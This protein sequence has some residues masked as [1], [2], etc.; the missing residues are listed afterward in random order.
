MNNFFS[1]L[2]TDYTKQLILL[3]FLELLVF[4]ISGVGYTSISND[5]YFNIGVDPLYWIFYGLSIPQTI[6]KFP[7]LAAAFDFATMGFLLLSIFKFNEKWVR[8]TVFLLLLNY[9]TLTGYLGHRNFQSGFVW[10]LMPLMFKSEK[11]KMLAFEM[12]RYWILF[13]YASSSIFIQF[14]VL[15]YC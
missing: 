13:F 2:R 14:T 6:M 11:N 15:M 9:L 8:C 1:S 12:L 10:V 4:L 3:V 5:P 7:I